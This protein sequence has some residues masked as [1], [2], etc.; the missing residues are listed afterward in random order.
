M[1]GM[2]VARGLA[3]TAGAVGAGMV[4]LALVGCAGRLE[5]TA[6]SAVGYTY[7]GP[8]VVRFDPALPATARIAAC[9][10]DDC[11]PAAVDRPVSAPTDEVWAVPQEAPFLG[12]GTIG[13]G[14]ERTLRIEA[15]D[16]E[17]MLVDGTFEIP[18]SVERTGVFGQ[19][20]G[21]FRFEPVEIDLTGEIG[22]AT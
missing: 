10:G 9:F 2:D 4:V 22:P 16:G 5:L 18:I 11:T 8:A 21:P 13:D 17:R 12:A 20:P 3:R 19:C 15:G 1:R 7:P 6:C 14:S